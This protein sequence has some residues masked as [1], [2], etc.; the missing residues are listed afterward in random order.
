[1][2]A[3]TKNQS[4]MVCR[5]RKTKCVY[6][7]G[8]K[9]RGKRAQSPARGVANTSVGAS[10]GASADDFVE[11]QGE[12]EDLK[13]RLEWALAELTE[14]R[15]QVHMLDGCL[16]FEAAHRWAMV[17]LLAKRIH[18]VENFCNGKSA[19]EASSDV[20]DYDVEMYDP[21]W[22]KGKDDLEDAYAEWKEE[23]ESRERAQ[24]RNA[25][26]YGFIETRDDAEYRPSSDADEME[27]DGRMGKETSGRRS[28]ES[29]SEDEE[30]N[31]RVA[32]EVLA[33]V[34]A[35]RSAKASAAEAALRMAEVSRAAAEIT[36]TLG[37]PAAD[38]SP[39][40]EEEWG[41]IVET[42]AAKIK[43]KAEL[44]REKNRKKKERQKANRL[45]LIAAGK[46]R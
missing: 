31:H 7:A 14:T 44:K 28:A 33:R 9:A 41:G 3:G 18:G 43:S 8:Y 19:D 11:L 10:A 23:L 2:E 27:V 1:V 25:V 45:A 30:E 6:P 42:E 22:Y 46:R 24:V 4:C 26:E 12:V 38:K 21:S 32:E 29:E 5:T 16:R 35:K 17:R 40:D 36:A 20:G 34:E 15:G 39:D 37:N 13:N